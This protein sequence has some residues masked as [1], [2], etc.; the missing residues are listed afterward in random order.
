M[1]GVDGADDALVVLEGPVGMVAAHDV[2]LAAVGLH[3]GHHVLDG[4]LVGAGLPLL[5]REVAEAAGEHAE[6]GR[7]D[8]AVDDE[9]DALALA[10]R[11]HSVGHA[12]DA[13]EVLGL[14]QQQRRP[15][16]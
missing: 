3:H 5:A 9:V 12:A 14:E 2:H 13:Q 8:V 15:R 7:G 4:V 6:V 1:R 16:G 11:L 10:P